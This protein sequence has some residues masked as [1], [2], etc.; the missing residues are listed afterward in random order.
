MTRANT[1]HAHGQFICDGA[2]ASRDDRGYFEFGDNLAIEV[3]LRSTVQ[4][5]TDHAIHV[6]LSPLSQAIHFSYD[7]LNN[8]EYLNWRRNVDRG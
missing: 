3:G 4:G 6:S 2:L 8:T 5:A 7:Y 1:Y